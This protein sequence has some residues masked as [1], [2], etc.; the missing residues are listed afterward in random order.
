[1]HPQWSFVAAF[2]FLREHEAAIVELLASRE[3]VEYADPI[4]G[5]RRR[6]KVK[7]RTC[8]LRPAWPTSRA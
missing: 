4:D 3:T 2:A 8:S 6:L 5:K 1:M 7:V